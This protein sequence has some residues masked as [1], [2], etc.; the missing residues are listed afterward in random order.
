MKNLI[1]ERTGLVT[2]DETDETYLCIHLVDQTIGIET[3]P[4]YCNGST[5]DQWSGKELTFKLPT[6]VDYDQI[7]KAIETIDIQEKIQWLV[8]NYE[9]RCSDKIA[10]LWNDRVYDLG[11]TI[12]NNIDHA[13]VIDASDDFWNAMSTEEMAKLW[14]L[15]SNSVVQDVL[16]AVENDDANTGIIHININDFAEKL[17]DEIQD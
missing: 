7:H 1:D 2:T 16:D 11:H 9:N 17:L 5:P 14:K 12:E 4:S 8:E 15:N 3:K 10:P 13:E 6:F